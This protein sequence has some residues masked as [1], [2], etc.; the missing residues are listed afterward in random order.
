MAPAPRPATLRRMNEPMRPPARHG[1]AIAG[2]VRALEGDIRH[3]V[4][5]LEEAFRTRDWA[6]VARI[7]RE[8]AAIADRLETLDP[9][10]RSVTMARAEQAMEVTRSI[11]PEALDDEAW[12]EEGW[13]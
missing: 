12:S 8:V 5:D 6:M 9:N 4:V 3:R 1:D 13:P 10:A 11:R 2:E 7:Y